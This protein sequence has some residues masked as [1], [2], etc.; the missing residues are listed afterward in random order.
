MQELK[1]CRSWPR[2]SSIEDDRSRQEARPDPKGRVVGKKGFDAAGFQLL[3]IGFAVIAGIGAQYGVGLGHRCQFIEHRHQ[4]LL[5]RTAAVGLRGHHDLVLFVDRC[6]AGIALHYAL[7]RGHLGRFVVRPIRQSHTALGALAL[8]R[9]ALE[10]SADVRRLALQPRDLALLTSGKLDPCRIVVAVAVQQLVHRLLHLGGL[11]HEVLALAAL[12]FARVAG[13]FHPV[14]GKHLPSDQPLPIADQQ[15]LRKHRA[16]RLTQA[17]HEPG[18]RAVVGLAV[19]RQCDELH[20]VAAG[21]F[22]PARAH[23]P[24]RVGQ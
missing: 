8:V 5:L 7:P 16:H 21:R 13:Q 18:Q 12:R 19:S 4:Q 6:Y 20:V 22:H 23:D 9:M 1:H 10:P 2:Y 17:A 15:H 3:Q 11:T 14:D 24:M